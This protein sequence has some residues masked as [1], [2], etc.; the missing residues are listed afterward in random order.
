[1]LSKLDPMKREEFENMKIAHIVDLKN[2]LRQ[3]GVSET[4]YYTKKQLLEIL[5]YQ[6]K[7]QSNS[8]REQS[9]Y[10]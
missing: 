6:L 5:Y 8:N 7:E 4:D 1:M 10:P 3:Y 2:T 9:N